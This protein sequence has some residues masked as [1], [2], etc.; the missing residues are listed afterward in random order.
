MHHLPGVNR[1][2]SIAKP[3]QNGIAPVRTGT[4]L[5]T[6]FSE[7]KSSID[8]A[9]C[10]IA[11]CTSS[12]AQSRRI[13]GALDDPTHIPIPSSI[14]QVITEVTEHRRIERFI[15][16]QVLYDICNSEIKQNFKSVHPTDMFRPANETK[17]ASRPF[18]F[19]SQT[20]LCRRRCICQDSN[21]LR[22]RQRTAPTPL[23]DQWMRNLANA[24]YH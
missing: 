4:R 9:T 16:R 3:E 18:A 19:K 7:Y 13:I 10:R 24:L 5:T 6:W 11:A 22:T 21:C 23:P 17:S 14:P 2:S 20:I 15:F 8:L 12:N 1:S